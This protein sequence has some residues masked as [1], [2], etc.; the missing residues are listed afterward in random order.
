MA[1]T[2][3]SGGAVTLV[4]GRRDSHDRRVLADDS[5]KAAGVRAR[6]R[7]RI[8][9]STLETIARLIPAWSA[10]S[11]WRSSAGTEPI[12]KYRAQPIDGILAL[13]ARPILAPWFQ[14][15]WCRSNRPLPVA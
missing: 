8:W 15:P 13:D 14:Y 3:V 12:M 7:A 2:N 1:V 4:A 6:H 10:S 9:R 11:S 5:D